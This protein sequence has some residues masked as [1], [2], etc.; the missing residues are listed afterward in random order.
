MFC[1][2]LFNKRFP[3]F[4]R[5]YV[6]GYSVNSVTYAS[7]EYWSRLKPSTVFA[8]DKNTSPSVSDD[9]KHDQGY[10]QDGRADY[11]YY[12]HDGRANCSSYSHDKENL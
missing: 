5:G 10:L 6:C 9:V 4:S 2:P 11:Q 8:R 12:L 3:S 7:Y 1:S